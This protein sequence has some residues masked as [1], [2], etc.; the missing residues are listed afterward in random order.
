MRVLVLIAVV[1]MGLEIQEIVFSVVE[2]KDILGHEVAENFV[3]LGAIDVEAE[4]RVFELIG[5]TEQVA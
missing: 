3:G 2:E 5:L 1:E 4:G